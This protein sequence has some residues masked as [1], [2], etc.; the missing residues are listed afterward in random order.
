[1][2]EVLVNL[3]NIKN[4][5]EKITILLADDHFLIRHAVR[6]VLSMQPD[7]QII[8]EACD[9]EEA[10]RLSIELQPRLVIID[11]GMPKLNGLEAIRK[12]KKA[13]PAIAILVLTIHTEDEYIVGV[14]QAGAAGY[15]I[16]NVFG[17]EILEAVRSVV[18][19]EMV[20]SPLIGKQ[21]LQDAAGHPASPIPIEGENKLTARE[22]EIL[23]LAARGMSNKEISLKEDISLRTVKGHLAVVFYKLKVGSRTEAV[24]TGLRAGI[25]SLEDL[26]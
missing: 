20:L 3:D 5:P 19:G 12:I 15:L 25:L 10:V 11:I 4:Q 8:G 13:C 16:K 9:G 6:N 23:K 1:M 2:N 18:A 22:L 14:L 7:L 24:I 26:E 21:L 17:K